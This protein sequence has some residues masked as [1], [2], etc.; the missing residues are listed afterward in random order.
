MSVARFGV[1]VAPAM[2]TTGNTANTSHHAG[3]RRTSPAP[4][5]NTDTPHNA[6][7]LHPLPSTAL[8]DYLAHWPRPSS[9]RSNPRHTFSTMS[10]SLSS[11][12]LVSHRLV[13]AASSAF[14]LAISSSEGGSGTCAVMAHEKFK[15]LEVWRLVRMCYRVYAH[16]A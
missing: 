4:P 16:L 6:R 12:L 5:I 2:V 3:T 1:G 13:I 7:P 15:H 9:R 10:A 11:V 8:T 14:S